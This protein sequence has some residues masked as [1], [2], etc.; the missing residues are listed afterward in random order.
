VRDD[1]AILELL[2]AVDAAEPEAS[3]A[4]LA[5][6]PPAWWFDAASEQHPQRF[7]RIDDGF[8]R[9]VPELLF[10]RS[11]AR[12]TSNVDINE[13][14]VVYLREALAALL[15]RAAD[16]ASDSR[17][18]EESLHWGAE[19]THWW[20]RLVRHGDELVDAVEQARIV[21]DRYRAQVELSPILASALASVASAADDRPLAEILWELA[22]SHEAVADNA[23]EWWTVTV[24]YA[25]HE[26]LASKCNFDRAFLL[27]RRAVRNFR[28]GTGMSASLNLHDATC[29]LVLALVSCGE[30]EQA[31]AELDATLAVLTPGS[32]VEGTLRVTEVYVTAASGDIAA[33]EALIEKLPRYAR[34]NP[35]LSTT[36]LGPARLIVHSARRDA[37]AVARVIR[38]LRAQDRSTGPARAGA[39]EW[40][41]HA[42]RALIRVGMDE[43]ASDVLDEVAMLLESTDLPHLEAAYHC[44]RIECQHPGVPMES[45]IR[46]LEL[47]TQHRIE[48]LLA[49]GIGA[50]G[51]IEAARAVMACDEAA[52]LQFAA[53]VVIDLAGLAE[54][55]EAEPE[56]QVKVRVRLFG[57]CDVERNGV[58]V[59]A[60]EWSGRKQ[61]RA[62][63]AYL[64]AN[65]AACHRDV[66][67]DLLWPNIDP[68][69]IT[70]RMAPLVSTMRAVLA[71]DSRASKGRRFVES[72]PGQIAIGLAPGDECDVREFQRCARACAAATMPEDAIQAGLR[73]LS[74]YGGPFM[75][76][77]GFDEILHSLRD[78]LFDRAAWVALRLAEKSDPDN[79]RGRLI[80]DHLQRLHNEDPLNLAIA[81]ALIARY[82]AVG[83][84]ARAAA[85]RGQFAVNSGILLESE[86][87]H[88]PSAR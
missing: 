41:I 64:L 67:A 85:V 33:A 4:A 15:D 37:G 9:L 78:A 68:R 88:L 30:L 47:A 8:C 25:I 61:A 55:I 50:P 80:T 32:I 5:N 6:H 81:E 31:R 29:N 40:R 69:R 44:V 39:I 14:V 16:P 77:E 51:G 42:V 27:L 76:G 83:A 7:A 53:T 45:A 87:P 20:S 74:L 65:D 22:L 43:I 75:A 3:R 72:R 66:I 60:T 24:D 13:G 58:P 23:D 70:G 12:Q 1:S 38:E 35:S 28:S 71:A 17:A 18:R 46:A 19:A 86:G 2:T 54:S 34:E 48:G 59:D 26:L 11:V 79:Q 52:E 21:L 10:L 36:A 57:G 49:N 82:D 56:P 63:M 84:T 73:A 62:I